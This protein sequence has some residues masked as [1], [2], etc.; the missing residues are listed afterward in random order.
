MEMLSPCLLLAVWTIHVL[1]STGRHQNLFTERICCR[2][3]S[4]IIYVGQ[5]I[6]GSPV[7]L[8]VGMCRTHCAASRSTPSYEPG[9]P[10]FPKHVSML[11]FLRSKKVRGPAGADLASPEMERAGPLASCGPS[12]DCV[13]A[14]VRVER[15]LLFEGPREVEVV[16][17]C[18]CEPRLMHCVRVPALKTYH[19]DTP[20]QSV[21][22]VGKCST[23]RGSLE[24]FSCVAIKFDS[25]LVETPS[26]VQL[27]Q[28]VSACE[29]RRSC[30]R[31]PYMEYYYEVTHSPV[32][33]KE[34]KL[35]EIDVGRCLGNCNTG[36]RCLL[37][38][39]VDPKAC[40]LQAPGPTSTCVPQGYESHVFRNQHGNIRTV[41][42]I[43][44]CACQS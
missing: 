11:E 19:H 25:A 27:V 15:V 23:A 7:S 8:D 28:T 12:A 34:E 33:D 42:A 6:S 26:R 32:G 22:D 10:A 1:P 18:Q 13:A 38:S 14:S 20:Y 4:H 5:D 21:L 2:R 3:Q 37:R 16:E 17:E 29:L 36:S 9:Q 40:L 43:T 44:S 31:V 30:Y 39:S 24:G 35:K 41:L